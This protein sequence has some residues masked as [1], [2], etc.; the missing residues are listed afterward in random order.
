MSAPNPDLDS[1]NNS[2][3]PGSH[4][5]ASGAPLVTQSPARH[6]PRAPRIASGSYNKDDGETFAETKRTLQ[7]RGKDYNTGSAGLQ[8]KDWE[9][10]QKRDEAVAILE[11]GEE[12]V[13]WVAASRNEV[14]PP[15]FLVPSSYP[16]LCQL[17]RSQSPRADNIY[18]PY[19]KPAPTTATSSSASPLKTNK[20]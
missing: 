18:S 6:S 16:L 12:L 7:A 8:G 5:H 15:F 17:P 13:M 10:Q 9:M 14:C 4:T 11:G 2:P 1:S 20:T 19:P 3:I